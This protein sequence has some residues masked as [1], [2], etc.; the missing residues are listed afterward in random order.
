M[1]GHASEHGLQIHIAFHPFGIPLDISFPILI[2]WGVILFI[3]IFLMIA[4]RIERFRMIEEYI[5]DF[6][7]NEIAIGLKTSNKIWFSFLLSLFLFI[8]IGNLSGLI[9][10]AISPNSNINVTASMA[11]LV[12]CLAQ[13]CGIFTHGFKHFKHLVPPGI[14]KPILI[15]MIPL[16]IISQLA[17][18]F[19]LAVR[20][21]ANLFAGHK[22]LTIFLGFI[23]MVS[24]FLKLIPILGVLI[25]SFFEIFVAFIQAFIF[26]Y[27][28]SFYISDSVKGSH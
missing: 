15:L 8:F 17:R 26:T 21:F 16:E 27:L 4:N 11:I 14:P 22:V 1:D 9:P 28:S 23:V 25:L 7:T 18:P 6:I 24:P 12:F 2:M 19:S 13:F 3:F 5:F 10:G 20:L